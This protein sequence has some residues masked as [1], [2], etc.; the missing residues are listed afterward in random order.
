MI[1]SGHDVAPFFLKELFASKCK[2]KKKKLNERESFETKLVV[3]V[4]KRDPSTQKV[5]KNTGNFCCC[6]CFVLFYK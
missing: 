4:Q 6:C 1:M 2:V 3:R 5:E